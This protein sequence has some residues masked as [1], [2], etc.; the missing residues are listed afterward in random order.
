MYIISKEIDYYDSVGAQFGIDKSIVYQRNE[1]ELDYTAIKIFKKPILNLLNTIN[2]N[3][4]NHVILN[5]ATGNPDSKCNV[6]KK[7]YVVGFCGKLYVLLKITVVNATQS[8]PYDKEYI[9]YSFEYIP[10]MEQEIKLNKKN[11]HDI[12]NYNKIIND[13]KEI[14]KLNCTDLFFQYKVPVFSFLL[15]SSYRFSMPDENPILNPVL[16]NFSF[17]RVK[18]AF[19][20]FQEIQQYIS[21]VI[22]NTEKETIVTNDKYKIIA[23]GFDT[24]TS[25]R[26]ESG[27]PKPRKTKNNSLT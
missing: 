4:P 12:S 1:T 25:F 26:K 15:A 23:A 13:I 11:K 5:I 20:A 3:F 17:Y 8:Y 19:T 18:D 2:L 10:Y 6:K 9:M 24:V 21:G 16:N 14:E 27:K 7:W 22:G